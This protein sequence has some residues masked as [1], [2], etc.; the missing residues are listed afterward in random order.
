MSEPAW[1]RRIAADRRHLFRDQVRCST[2][3]SVGRV[4][5]PARPVAG[6]AVE[7]APV[8]HGG[9]AAP[10]GDL[11]AALLRTLE[12]WPEGEALAASSDLFARVNADGRFIARNPA[13]SMWAAFD[14]LA[15]R[16]AVVVVSGGPK[17][18][19]QRLVMLVAS[20]RVLRTADAL[21]AW[22]DEARDLRAAWL[23]RR[24]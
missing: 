13:K 1:L 18:F 17:R 19:G 23:E 24:A 11:A 8:V 15:R 2:G 14:A 10:L 21:A 3:F 7:V 12:A 22:E 6:R 5:V 20:G 9:L 16:G 4:P